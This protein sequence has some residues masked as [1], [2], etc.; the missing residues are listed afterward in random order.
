MLAS[1]WGIAVCLPPDP[2]SRAEVTRM[3]AG[4]LNRRS[5]AP[6]AYRCQTAYQV[7][8]RSAVASDISANS[9]TRAASY[10]DGGTSPRLVAKRKHRGRL[11]PGLSVKSP[12]VGGN[13]IRTFDTRTSLILR[14][15]LRVALMPRRWT[16]PPSVLNHRRPVR[17]SRS[18]L[19]SSTP[20]VAGTSHMPETGATRLLAMWVGVSVGSRG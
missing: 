1:C 10:S 13:L 18:D 11:L 6:I 19:R 9:T 8:S 7:R 15:K 14:A 2:D 5:R 16:Q 4:L 3:T 20:K 12:Y 17:T